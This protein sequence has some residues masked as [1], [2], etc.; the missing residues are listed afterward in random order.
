MRLVRIMVQI[1]LLSSGHTYSSGVPTN[2]FEKYFKNY[3]TT[4]QDSNLQQQLFP[5]PLGPQH[6]PLQGDQ[7]TFSTASD[8]IV[9]RRISSRT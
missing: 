5:T 8:A 7:A 3:T 9:A 1:V 6:F 4:Q 2:Y